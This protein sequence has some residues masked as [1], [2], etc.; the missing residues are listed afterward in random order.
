MSRT[1][2]C[3]RN[4]NRRPPERQCKRYTVDLWTVGCAHSRL[5]AARNPADDPW[6]T[7]RVSHRPPTG[8]RLP[9]SPTALDLSLKIESRNVKTI[10]RPPALASSTPGSVQTIGATATAL[11][12]R[13][14]TTRSTIQT[15]AGRIFRGKKKAAR[16]KPR[17]V[18]HNPL[19]AQGGGQT[20]TSVRDFSSSCC[21]L[22]RVLPA[23]AGTWHK[24]QT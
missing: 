6:R 20:E 2:A 1:S 21:N 18:R 13:L 24:P 19:L 15:C 22:C 11:A 12:G 14:H 7:R 8:Y 17:P 5:C 10:S 4:R 23:R 9:T 16:E 3:S